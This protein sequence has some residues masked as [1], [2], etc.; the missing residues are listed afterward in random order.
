MAKKTKI[1]NR[2]FCDSCVHADWHKQQWNLNHKGE[3]IT[4]W[5]KKGIFELGEVR[6]T[7]RACGK[8]KPNYT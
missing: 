6:G 1:D 8:Y 2:P 3:P 7:R 4:F 5:C